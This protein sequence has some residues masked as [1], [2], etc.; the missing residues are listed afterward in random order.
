[1]SQI[2]CSDENKTVELGIPRG[3]FIAQNL[4][5]L[6]LNIKSILDICCGRG[7]VLQGI[8]LWYPEAACY[9]LDMETFTDWNQWD[10]LTFIKSSL[11]EFIKNTSQTFDLVLMMETWRNWSQ[12][13]DGGNFRRELIDWFKWHTKYF[14]C[15][16]PLLELEEYEHIYIGN[17][18]V[19]SRK[20]YDIPIN[21][22]Y[23]ENK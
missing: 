19:E 10:K 16:G 7:F 11:Q 22:I 9:G 6:K 3:E 4:L 13:D 21:L 5:S 20:G 14:V 18:D 15:S 1:M 8:K 12:Q 17:D 23:M 2:W